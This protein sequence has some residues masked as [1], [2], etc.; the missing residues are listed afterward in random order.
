MNEVKTYDGAPRPD[1]T[2]WLPEIG[3]RSFWWPSAATA[4]EIF[5]V[6]LPLVLLLIHR[7]EKENKREYS[8]KLY[9]A[10]QAFIYIYRVQL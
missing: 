6:S 2:T 1:F 5:S 7:Q 3:G 10:S 4:G 8:L 9:A